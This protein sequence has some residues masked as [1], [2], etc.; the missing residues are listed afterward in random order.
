MTTRQRFLLLLIYGG[1]GI[2][3]LAY[4]VLWTRM[5]SLMFGISI[6]GVVLTV[7]A[8]M[9]GLGAG[10]LIAVRRGAVFSARG[11]LLLLAILEAAIAFYAISLPLIMPWLDAGLLHLGSGF[12]LGGWQALQALLVFLLLFPAAVGMGYA[13]PLA[14]KAAGELRVSLGAMYGI[15]ALGGGLGAVLPLLLLPLFGW[16]HA[17]WMVAVFGLLLAA[18]AGWLALQ[19]E[20]KAQQKTAKSPLPRP[21]L[22]DLL[23]Y[24][25]IGA[26]ALMLEVVWTRLFGMV[27]LRTEYVLAVLLLV[28]LSGIGFGSVLARRVQSRRH[29]SL[30]L[31]ILPVAGALFAIGGQYFLPLLSQWA[32]RSDYDSLFAAMLLQGGAVL[33]LSLPVTLAL[34]AWLPLLSRYFEASADDDKLEDTGGIGSGGWWYGANSLGAALGALLGGFVLIPWLGSAA[35]LGF[36]A[37]LLFICGMRW[38]QD[39]RF[40]LALP[41]LLLL[42]WPLR[43]FPPVAD[44]LPDMASAHELSLYE[45]AVAITHVVERTTGQRLL[46]SDLQRMD[47]SSDPTAVTVQKNQARLPL[48][49]HP[50]AKSILFL[51]LGTGITAAGSLPFPG[52]ERTAIELSQG[53]IDAASGA[54]AAVNGG[55][56]T[57]MRVQRDDARRFLRVDHNYYDVIVG[58]L[59]HPDMV[60]RANLL[61][62]QQFKR[63]RARLNEGGVFVQWLALNQFDIPMLKV[64]LHTFRSAFSDTGRE[65]GAQALVFVDG[66]RLALV[67]LQ[68]DLHSTALLKRWQG[69]LP[70]VRRATTGGEG[71]WTWMGRFWGE[72]PSFGRD[73]PIQNEWSPVIEY[74][75]PRLRYAGGMDGQAMWRWMLSWRQ[76][77]ERAA[78][79]LHVG[80][81]NFTSFKRAWAASGLDVHLWMA[82]LAGEERQAVQWAQLAQ[83]ANPRDRWSAFALADRMLMSLEQGAVPDMNR[84]QALMRILRLR[85]DHE[86][87]LRAMMRLEKQ[88]GHADAAEKWRSKLAVISPLAFDVRKR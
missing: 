3:A 70:E 21:P 26:A 79:V 59:F 5:L 39:R 64:V 65:G 11:A 12:S 87:A 29:L 16:Q 35:A 36:S 85:P 6:F 48:L 14:L 22:F 86:Q 49:L 83:R 57:N 77:A 62:L 13:F 33:L 41:V 37:V 52:L 68:S 56:M 32:N 19:F 76:S 81:A 71:L 10:S 31:G 9:A 47:A 72:I 27:L 2:S 24:A 75:L 30:W 69:M 25:G 45:D 50:E 42:F 61:S 43:H 18:L 17:L 63:A 74:A 20:A 28:Y 82:E 73:V 51:G 1:T 58:D 67:G 55:V 15:N 40:W 7:A 4:E 38:V 88:A 46:L 34:G 53:A 60:G 80:A 84:R 66:Y 44:L 23:V 78:Q 8:F 54:F